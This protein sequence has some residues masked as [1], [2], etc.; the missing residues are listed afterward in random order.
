MST[1]AKL[2]FKMYAG[3]N[4]NEVLR[5]ESSLKTYVP[6]TAITNSAPVVITAPNHVITN[7][8][9]VR[10]TNI[11]GMTELNN[12]ETYYQITGVASN[13]LTINTINSLA[14]KPYVSGGIVEYNTPV[15][16]TGYTAKMQIRPNVDSST[17][18]YEMT[19]SN[20]GI[21]IDNTNKK[22]T[23]FIPATVTSTF[24]FTTAVYALEIYAGTTS[25]VLIYGSMG[26]TKEVVK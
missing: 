26:L 15:D 1:P 2:N 7:E 17:L 12:T 13:T 5:W 24:N 19:T 18:I 21:T 22:I 9:R 23:L 4:F 6:I 25:F 16:L 11:V 20:G 14:F 3:T 8:W 10:L